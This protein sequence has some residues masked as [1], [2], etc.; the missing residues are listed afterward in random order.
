VGTAHEQL[1]EAK[2]VEMQTHRR[3][4]KRAGKSVLK[5]AL[6]GDFE[7]HQKELDE[8]EKA[9]SLKLQLIKWKPKNKHTG[10]TGTCRRKACMKVAKKLP[11]EKWGQYD[12]HGGAL[13]QGCAECLTTWDRCFKHKGTFFDVV[14]TANESD[15]KDQTGAENATGFRSCAYDLCSWELRVPLRPKRPSGLPYL[16]GP[17]WHY[18]PPCNGI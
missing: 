6:G 11:K 13:G 14:D 12:A 5:D 4:Q 1:K 9:G 7:E 8:K 15:L 16:A 10:T 2:K 17:T 3:A 18:L